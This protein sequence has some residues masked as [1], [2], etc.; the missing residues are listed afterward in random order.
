MGQKGP[1]PKELTSDRG[2]AVM[3]S[4]ERNLANQKTFLVTVTRLRDYLTVVVYSALRLG[5][6]RM[7]ASC[8]MPS[9]RRSMIGARSIVAA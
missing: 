1:A 3:D 9:S 2:I 5:G 7:P 8:W 6:R 4:R